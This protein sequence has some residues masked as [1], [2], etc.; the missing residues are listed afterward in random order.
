M[1]FY[2]YNHDNGNWP[3]LV[4]NAS[5]NCHQDN[6]SVPCTQLYIQ[7]SNTWVY[8]GMQYFLIFALKQS[9]GA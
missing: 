1:N 9:V 3:A 5:F 7:C 8:R 4:S 6:M 2:R